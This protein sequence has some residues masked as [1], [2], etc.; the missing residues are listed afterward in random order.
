MVGLLIPRNGGNGAGGNGQ[1]LTVDCDFEGLGKLAFA[2]HLA[3]PYVEVGLARGIGCDGKGH[4]TARAKRAHVGPSAGIVALGANGVGLRKAGQG[5]ILDLKAIG[6]GT[7]GRGISLHGT[8]F[9]GGGDLQI[10]DVGGVLHGDDGY[11][12]F[13]LLQRDGGKRYADEG[14]IRRF[15]V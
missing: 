12:V 10:I 9:C 13:S 15:V 6:R 8:N 4:R 5:G 3:E 11:D 7:F 14:Q 2:S 1:G